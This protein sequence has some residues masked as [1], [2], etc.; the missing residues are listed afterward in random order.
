MGLSESSVH[1]W[2]AQAEID[3]RQRDGLSPD[4]RAELSHLRR[5]LR[6][7][8]EERDIL[9]K[10]AMPVGAA[11]R[12]KMGERVAHSCLAGGAVEVGRNRVVLRARQKSDQG[13]VRK[14]VRTFATLTD[15]LLALADWLTLQGVTHVAMESTGIYWRPL[16]NLL[17]E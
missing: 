5:E 10:V 14:E 1:R 9:A 3:A 13:V 15:E 17:E 11:P 16:W 6:A 2:L 4:E 8:R 12:M 7:V